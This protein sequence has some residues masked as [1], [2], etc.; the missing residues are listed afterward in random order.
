MK[1]K[2]EYNKERH[3]NSDELLRYHRHVLSEEESR[4]IIKHLEGC[5]L[6][7]DAMKGIS[8]MNDAMGIYNIVRDLR[9][10]M[11]KRYTPK[12]TILYRFELITILLA[13]FIIGLILFLGYYFLIFRR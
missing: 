5:E 7:S 4:A 1:S 8:E 2:F 13:F 3:L 11:I 12:K 9:R 6:C 10:K